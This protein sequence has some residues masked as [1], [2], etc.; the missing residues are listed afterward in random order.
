M[1]LTR[2][3]YLSQSVPFLKKNLIIGLLLLTPYLTANPTHAAFQESL[4]G[5]RP[6]S[7]VGA[8]TAMADDANAPAYNP[9]GIS[10]LSQ[11]EVT[12]MYAQLYSGLNFYAGEETSRLGL[13]YFS[14]VPTIKDKR[15]GSY[16]FSWTNF[17]ASNLYREDSFSLSIADSYEFE[18]SPN[19]PIIAYGANLKMLKRSFSPDRRSSADPVFQNGRDENAF[20]ADIGLMLRPHFRLLP[21]LKFG[22]SGQNVT[23]PDMGLL[24]SDRV[25]ARYTLGVAYQDPHYR[26]ANPAIDV[27]RRRGET[28]VTFGFES[29]LAKDTFAMRAGGNEDELGGGLGYQFRLF[30]RLLMRL[31]YALLWPL[32][33]EGTNGSHRISIT[34]SF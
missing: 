7:M 30:E 26:F 28:I 33:V 11:T 24:V 27:A 12:F 5:A 14:Y 34:T 32:N 31:D 6:A 1:R 21:G 18:S 19:R 16:A 2:V 29:W 23:E 20:T 4:W 10:W 15:Y 8:F 22:F 17:V 25:P 9:A 3:S 13:G